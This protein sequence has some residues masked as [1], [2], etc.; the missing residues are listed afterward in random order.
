MKSVIKFILVLLTF[1]LASWN[2]PTFAQSSP[3]LTCRV[4]GGVTRAGICLSKYAAGS[5]SVANI[6]NI[7]PGNY[8][9]QWNTPVASSCSSNSN[10]CIY[11]VA[12]GNNDVDLT[13]TAV[14][15][16]LNTGSVSSFSVIFYQQA[17]CGGPGNYY[18]C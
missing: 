6:L 14:V 5:Y 9:I 11:S 18:Y 13:T 4:N 10:I 16:N 8:S 12:A 7:E 2:V 1:S 3:S 15:T 17:T